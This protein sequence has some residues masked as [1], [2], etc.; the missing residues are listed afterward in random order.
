MRLLRQQL[1]EAVSGLSD[2]C[3]A[4][5]LVWFESQRLSESDS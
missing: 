5:V 4:N 2:Q 3:D 1:E